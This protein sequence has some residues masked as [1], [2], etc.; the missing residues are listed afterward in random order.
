M[1]SD[2]KVEH[3]TPMFVALGIFYVSMM[4]LS[5]IIVGKLISVGHITLTAGIL[6]YPLVWIVSDIK[7]EIYG[8][9]L[10]MLINKM[11]VVMSLVMV[12]VFTIT[13]LMPYPPFWQGQSA[14]TT[15]M[16]QIPRIVASSLIAYYIGQWLN[17]MVVSW[18]KVKTRG[19]GFGWRAILSTVVG[20][21]GDT[22][23]FFVLA[24]VGTMSRACQLMRKCT[25][26]LRS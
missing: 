1:L 18:M 9:K 17:D 22:G 3:A 24:F 16:K 20:Q 26:S 12:L 8:M 4:L 21:I 23:L 15:V 10:S 7:T 25:Q 19:R 14:F 11:A 5:N 13:L 6:I 2:T